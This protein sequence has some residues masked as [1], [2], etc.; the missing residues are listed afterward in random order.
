MHRRAKICQPLAKLG[1]SGLRGLW[2]ASEGCQS[3][4]EG[5]A[6]HRSWRAD[7]VQIQGKRCGWTQGEDDSDVLYRLPL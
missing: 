3:Y 5:F 7:P 4:Q 2:I 1:L 6:L